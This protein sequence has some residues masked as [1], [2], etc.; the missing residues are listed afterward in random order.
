MIPKLINF[1]YGINSV[2]FKKPF[3]YFHYLAVLSAKR[4]NN[5]C[6]VMLH[7]RFESQNN[8]WWEKTK[9]LVTLK[10]ISYVPVSFGG[11]AVIYPEH[12]GDYLRLIIL[13]EY[14]GIYLDIDTI[15]VK[16]F[17]PLL[18]HLCVMG[19]EDFGGNTNGLCNAVILS[20]PNSTFIQRWLE[21]FNKDFE[22]H[23][24]N[25]MSVRVPH[26]LSWL[27]PDIVHVLPPASFFKYNWHNIIDI[28]NGDT[29]DLTGVYCIHLW[30]SK[31]YHPILKHI[32]PEDVMS[33]DCLYNRIG[34]S[35]II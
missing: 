25:H 35:Y 15:T 16:S 4:A 28:F 31:L 33:R 13:K 24:W 9:E 23:D 18:S 27:Y 14:G 21:R 1:I 30:E 2:F 19:T 34:Q 3:S 17:D 7:Y 10:K 12:Q 8:E 20:E 5:N 6:E 26:L 29:S 32:T 22:P 11:K